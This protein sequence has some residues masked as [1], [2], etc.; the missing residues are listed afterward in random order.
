MSITS[1]DY[2]TILRDIHEKFD[3]IKCILNDI[4]HDTHTS[5][6]YFLDVKC[7]A[8]AVYDGDKTA[9]SQKICLRNSYL[10]SILILNVVQLENLIEPLIDLVSDLSATSNFSNTYLNELYGNYK[11]LLDKSQSSFKTSYVSHKQSYFV[12]FDK[13]VVVSLLEI[14]E[15]IKD[16]FEKKYDYYLDLPKKSKLINIEDQPF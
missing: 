1:V 6:E 9:E 11:I 3:L 4:L 16:S 14:L 8:A 12:F 13:K 10:F 2:I 5:G 7:L 15:E